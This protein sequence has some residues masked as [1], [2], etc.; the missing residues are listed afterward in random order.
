MF[1]QCFESFRMR[2]FRS[3]EL[4]HEAPEDISWVLFFRVVAIAIE[5]CQAESGITTSGLRQSVNDRGT[6]R[7]SNSNN[8]QTKIIYT[9]RSTFQHPLKCNQSRN[10]GVLLCP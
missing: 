9:S 10:R 3:E 4:S 5:E 1:M 8:Y 2:T 6:N 7:I